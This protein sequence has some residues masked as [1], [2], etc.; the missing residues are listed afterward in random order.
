[1][2]GHPEAPW[3]TVVGV[4]GDIHQEDLESVT[5][6]EFYLAYA[7][8]PQ[9]RWTNIIVRSTETPATL[10]PGFRAAYREMDPNLPFR[11]LSRMRD[12]VEAA[13]ASAQ[14]RTS[15]L[16]FFAATALVLASA[17]LYGTL[18]NT[19]QRRTREIGIRMAIGA[20]PDR[21]LREVL[22]SGMTLAAIGMTGGVIAALAATRTL[23]RFLFG[24]LPWEPTV[25]TVVVAIL[26]T[27]AF[28]ACLA[29]ARRA[30][31]VDPASILG[32]E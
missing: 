28:G 18:L 11:G 22:R 2:S 6:R 1:M 29:P 23:D 20:H 5:P 4:V 16:M 10:E 30:T 17:G 3:V 13:I 24:V 8:T 9:F 27:V 14:F 7:Q 19:V 15:L 12:R 31:R 32:L 25:F 26:A 21:V